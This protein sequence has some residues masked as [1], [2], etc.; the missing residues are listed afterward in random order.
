MTEDFWISGW[1]DNTTTNHREYWNEGRRGRHGHR[2]GIA[3]DS[4]HREFRAPWLSFPDVPLHAQMAAKTMHA[5][6]RDL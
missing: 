2:S 6:G 5:V 1:H 4:M 3:P